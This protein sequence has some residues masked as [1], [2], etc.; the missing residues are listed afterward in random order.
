MGGLGE[1]IMFHCVVLDCY[2][3][4]KKNTLLF[5]V[6]KQTMEVILVSVRLIIF[7][8]S[9]SASILKIASGCYNL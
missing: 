8:R 3:H 4:R 6:I 5:S 2:I 9:L 1:F 7:L